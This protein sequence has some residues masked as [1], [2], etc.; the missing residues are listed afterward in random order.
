MGVF[1]ITITKSNGEVKYYSREDY[2][3][4]P[5][6]IGQA[7]FY[8]SF[9]EAKKVL[10]TCDFTENSTMCDGTIEPPRLIHSGLDMCNTNMKAFGT[11]SIMEV[12]MTSVFEKHVDA[13]IKKPKNVIYNY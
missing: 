10:E 8:S 9:E 5:S 4:W 2:G 3:W 1:V 12:S 13:E 6:F 11:I 7:T